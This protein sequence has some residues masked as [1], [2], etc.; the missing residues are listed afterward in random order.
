MSRL[1]F[2]RRL[3]PL[4]LLLPMPLLAFASCAEAESSGP[5]D[6]DS[7]I[8]VPPPPPEEASVPP[9]PVVDGGCDASDPNCVARPISCAEAPWCPV[10][11]TV[12]T[13]FALTSVWGTGP[14]DVWAVGSGGTIIHW[15]G[16]AW[17][18]TP[19][20]VK[21]TF[22]AVWGR[23]ATDVWAVAMT[24]TIFHTTGFANG[25][26]EWKRATNAVEPDNARAA[27]AVWGSGAGDLR[28]GTRARAYFDP[29][30]GEFPWIDQYTLD[31]SDGGVAW[32]AVLGEGNVHAFWGASA[33]DIWLVA[34]NSEKNGWERGMIKHG[35]PGAK[36]G[37]EWTTVDSQS[38]VVLEG[39]WGSS[40][41]DIWAVGD[42]G[43]IRRR[44]NGATRWE[45]I[46]SPTQEPL[47]AIWG[48]AANDVWVV[49]DSGTILHFDGTTW[50][51]SL[52]AFDL[53][54][55]PNLYGVWGSSANDVW[56]VGDNVSL[57]FTGAKP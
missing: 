54:L 18:I 17:V 41:N 37:L 13:R 11:T 56:I 57:H 25:T 19:T 36:G 55:K 48:S 12:S 51:K 31:E 29:D 43:T 24:D 14:S 20:T 49:G 23:S 50:S 52:A 40:A 45:I 6:E 30:T 34:D 16:T 7:G 44:T 53:G 26:A 21:N 32:N 39:I 22:H 5:E 2:D 1:R 42:K 3:V 9:V 38:T 33:T 35:T 8:V 4:A 46:A 47:H 10:P 28:I 27:T 15:N